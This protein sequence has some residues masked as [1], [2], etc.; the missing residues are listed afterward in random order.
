[1]KGE[2]R[3]VCQVVQHYRPDN[4]GLNGV[5][6]YLEDEKE[7]GEHLQRTMFGSIMGMERQRG[8]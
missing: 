2:N 6:E 3:M 1:M 5:K 4:D 7:E 8:A